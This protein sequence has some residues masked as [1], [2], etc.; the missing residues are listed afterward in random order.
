MVTA[1]SAIAPAAGTTRLSGT[2]AGGTTQH[3]WPCVQRKIDTVQPGQVWSGPSLDEAADV[4]RTA[5]MRRLVAEVSARRLPIADAE[6]SVVDFVK[7]L[8][9]AQ[10]ERTATAVFAD[11]LRQLDAERSEI[12]RGIERYGARQQ[13][14]AVKLRAQNAELSDIRAS[15]DTARATQA[16]ET[17]LWDTRIFDER[18]RSLTYVCEVPILIEQRLFALGRAMTGAL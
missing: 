11:L 14:L 4:E 3:R 15:G 1:P 13:D 12:I 8:P 18:R 2:A 16:Q 5:E 6:K 7:G 9:E 17:I 10:R